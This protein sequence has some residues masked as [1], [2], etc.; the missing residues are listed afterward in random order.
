[1]ILL[2]TF[3]VWVSSSSSLTGRRR[4]TSVGAG[5]AALA[6]SARR[7]ACGAAG[8]RASGFP[9]GFGFLGLARVFFDLAAF[10]G[11][12]L[13]LHLFFFLRPAAGFRLGIA[14]GLG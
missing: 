8:F 1:M 10:G 11:N 2:P 7:G 12:T 13:R 6:G 9:A 3:L 5:C 4:A 14:A